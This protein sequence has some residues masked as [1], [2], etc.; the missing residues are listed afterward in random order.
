MPAFVKR[1]VGSSWGTTALDGAKVWPAFETKK[2]M[3]ALRI[4]AAE[5]G[6]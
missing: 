1:S 5:V 2:S 3:N 6:R 4:S